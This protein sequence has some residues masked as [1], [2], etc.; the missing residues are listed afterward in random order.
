MKA[1]IKQFGFL[2][3]LLIGFSIS[4]VAQDINNIPEGKYLV[5]GSFKLKNNAI[6][7]SEYVKKMNQYDVN[8]AYHPVKNYYHVYIKSYMGSENGYSDVLQ[9]RKETEF[10]IKIASYQKIT[11]YLFIFYS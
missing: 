7:F 3:I 10:K 6:G 2:V 9:M 8:L 1:I 11:R 4:S 5:I